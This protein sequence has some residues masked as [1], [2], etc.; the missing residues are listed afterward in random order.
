MRYAIPLIVASAAAVAANPAAAA[1][2]QV[3]A[4]GPVIELNVFESV[5][6][7]PDMATISAGVTTE[8]M[9]AVE[10]LRQN[11]AQMRRVIDRIKSLGVDE[12]D[13]QTT[14]INLNAR[15]DYD[16]PTRQQVFRGY[17]VSNRVSVKLREIDEVGEVLDALVAAGANDLNG[18]S[19]S[20]E[21]DA[22]AKA[23]A[24]R[25]ALDRARAQAMDYARWAGYSNVR[26]LEV[27]ESIQGRGP[28]PY[29]SDGI[30]LTAARAESAPVQPGRLS[31][32][33]SVTVKY[34]MTN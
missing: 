11:S 29:A 12:D 5:D 17:Q 13:I 15:Y 10:A 18:P 24:R 6:A 27:S 9:T 4:E 2:V 7:D 21:D 1:E 32:G 20:L 14:G 22:A 31:T 23:A 30:V 19:F 26:L 34:E 33:I 16:Q 25:S 28:M 3:Q 8:A